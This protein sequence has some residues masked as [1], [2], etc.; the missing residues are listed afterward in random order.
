M[1]VGEKQN[2]YV[3]ACGELI[4]ITD[5]IESSYRFTAISNGAVGNAIELR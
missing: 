1:I 2:V 4:L 3:G 5:A